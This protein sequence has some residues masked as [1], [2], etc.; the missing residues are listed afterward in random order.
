[1]LCDRKAKKKCENRL[2][3]KFYWEMNENIKHW[4]CFFFQLSTT[5]N[6]IN[7]YWN[8]ETHHLA[9]V[10]HS[11]P[12]NESC[13]KWWLSWKFKCDS[14]ISQVNWMIIFRQIY[15]GKKKSFFDK[16][17]YEMEIANDSMEKKLLE[18]LN[19]K[20][21]CWFRRVN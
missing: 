20:K 15:C 19:Y 11:H 18:N 8:K 21:I 13:K 4:N 6:P 2:N 3:S 10:C 17:N 1:M 9:S 14:I 7:Y 5:K 12:C 16:K